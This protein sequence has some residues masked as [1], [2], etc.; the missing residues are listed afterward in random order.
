MDFWTIIGGAA[1]IVAI[2]TPIYSICKNRSR[3]KR[4]WADCIDVIERKISNA[5]RKLPSDTQ[6]LFEVSKLI[7]DA[8]GYIN[9]M[10]DSH[11]FLPAE[12]KKCDSLTC[13][14][15]KISAQRLKILVE[16]INYIKWKTVD[17]SIQHMHSSIQI[18]RLF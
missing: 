13:D 6:V 5:E 17:E 18:P 8:E 15:A 14:F 16:R 7:E 4:S 10:R 12:I 1:A 3:L 2:A 9:E 11:L